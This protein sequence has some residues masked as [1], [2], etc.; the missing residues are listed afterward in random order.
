M[1]KIVKIIKIYQCIIILFIVTL[2]LGMTTHGAMAYYQIPTWGSNFS[3]GLGG[4]S[5]YLNYNNSQTFSSP[6]I[7]GPA[8]GVYYP[9]NTM[10]NIYN[11][12]YNLNTGYNQNVLGY[13]NGS[14]YSESGNQ[15]INA[16]GYPFAYGYIDQ[17]AWT[18]QQTNALGFGGYSPVT[19]SYMMSGNPF[20]VYYNPVAFTMDLGIDTYVKGVTNFWSGLF[21]RLNEEEE[22]E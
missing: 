1:K 2:A 15:N 8:M 9:Y 22:E 13:Y 4:P 21:N 20:N 11:G 19:S 16:L 6:Y 17:M 18:A 12:A 5:N 3:I 14:D 7:Y 10:F